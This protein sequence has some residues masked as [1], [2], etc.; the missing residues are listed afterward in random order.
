MYQLIQPE[1]NIK[2]YKKNLTWRREILTHKNVYSFVNHK[3][4]SFHDSNRCTHSETDLIRDIN[5]R[6]RLKR[7]SRINRGWINIREIEKCVELTDSAKI[8]IH[9]VGNSL[10]GSIN[11]II[12]QW[13]LM[14]TVFSF[15]SSTLLFQFEITEWTFMNCGSAIFIF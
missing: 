9:I 4:R 3:G 6:A 8:N 7:N 11:N 12:M 13:V 5:H 10:F 14:H 15:S 1:T 2:R